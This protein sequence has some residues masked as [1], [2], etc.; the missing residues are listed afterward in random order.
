MERERKHT[1]MLNGVISRLRIE[2]EAKDNLIRSMMG[3]KSNEKGAIEKLMKQFK[4]KI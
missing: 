4:I 3:L 2:I 1:K